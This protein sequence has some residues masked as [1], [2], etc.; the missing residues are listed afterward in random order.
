MPS[1]A[2]FLAVLSDPE[3]LQLLLFA[4]PDGV[5]ATDRED[6][7]ILY[8]GS[9]ESLFGFSPVDVLGHPAVEL[10]TNPEEFE[11]FAQLLEGEGWVVGIEVQARRKDGPPFTASVSAALLRDRTGG[12]LGAVAYVRDHSKMRAIEDALR[13]NNRRLNDLV[14]TLNHVASHDQLTGLLHRSSAMDSIE[15]YVLACGTAGAK[16]GVALLDI[17]H[18]KTVNDSFGHLVGDDVLAIL[19]GVLRQSGRQHDIV[20]RFGG[21]EFIAFLPGADLAAVTGFAERARR[22]IAA[23]RVTIRDAVVTVTISAGVSAVPGC[24]PTLREAIR[25]ADDRLLVAKRAGRNRVIAG[26]VAERSAA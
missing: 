6:R 8:T 12:P 24:A 18:F 21:E 15:T 7:I 4:C 9:S 14:G 1:E 22:A 23:E 5:I 11:H 2:D 10:F 25:I 17:D 19:A 16:F 26:D 20:G 3:S 13:D